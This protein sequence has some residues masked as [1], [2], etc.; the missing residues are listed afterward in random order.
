[1]ALTSLAARF[2]SAEEINT[3]ALQLRGGTGHARFEV[4]RQTAGFVYLPPMSASKEAARGLGAASACEE[5]ASID[6]AAP[7]VQLRR[8]S[9]VVRRAGA[10]AVAAAALL[11]PA[12]QAAPPLV[13]VTK[14]TVAGVGVGRPLIS[15]AFAWGPSSSVVTMPS[16]AGS[17]V[18]WQGT[19]KLVRGVAVFSD[20]AQSHAT[21]VFYGGPLRTTRGDRVGTTLARL[22]RL[23]RCPATSA[24]ASA[25]H[26]LLSTGRNGSSVS[27]SAARTRSDS[28]GSTSH[29]GSRGCGSRSAFCP[30]R[31]RPLWLRQLRITAPSI[32]FH[33]RWIDHERQVIEDG[34]A[35][36]VAAGAIASSSPISRGDASLPGPTLTYGAF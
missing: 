20:A 10:V 23:L 22:R 34:A 14:G 12:A 33:E 26:C 27:P 3:S 5:G 9:A 13:N 19:T 15:F 7:A 2:I 28:L 6:D 18:I 21:S 30:R 4:R 31:R 11:A 35:P 17:A 36:G 16:G 29:D 8:Q 24:S 25:R 1:M 32:A